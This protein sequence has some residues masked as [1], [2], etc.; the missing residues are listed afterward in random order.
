MRWSHFQVTWLADFGSRDMH[1]GKLFTILSFD[2]SSA[3]EYRLDA[4][5]IRQG[6]LEIFVHFWN[7][8]E[9]LWTS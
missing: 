8:L 3:L 6:T 5:T 2:S 1:L 7:P 9:A 4:Q